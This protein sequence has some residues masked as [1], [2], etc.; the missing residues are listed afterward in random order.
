MP[1]QLD[2]Q[3]AIATNLIRRRFNEA[4]QRLNLPVTPLP[5]AEVERR[6]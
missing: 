5:K 6:P 3:V 1:D 4:Q 2:V